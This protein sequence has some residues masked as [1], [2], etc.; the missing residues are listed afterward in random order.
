MGWVV[1]Q[2]DPHP[3]VPG[4]LQERESPCSHWGALSPTHERSGWPKDQQPCV[5]YP[6]VLGMRAQWGRATGDWGLR[7]AEG[8]ASF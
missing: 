5:S 4:R 3:R 7:V 2:V 6:I 1:S 8:R